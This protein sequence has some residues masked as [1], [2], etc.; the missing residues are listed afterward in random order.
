[1]NE[2]MQLKFAQL[3]AAA[4][5]DESLMTRL[6]QEPAVVMAERGIVIPGSENKQIVLVEDTA[7]T[8][9]IVLPCRPPG[10]NKPSHDLCC[11]PASV[12]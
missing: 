1:M 4:W 2:E 7:D 6:R 12:I 5:L 3:I 9:H 8:L 10:G 11:L